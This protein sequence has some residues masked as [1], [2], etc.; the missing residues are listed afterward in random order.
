MPPPKYDEAALMAEFLKLKMENPV[1]TRSEFFRLKSI[2]VDYGLKKFGRVMDE[3]WTSV[4]QFSVQKIVKEAGLKLGDQMSRVFKVNRDLMEQA[5]KKLVSQKKGAKA[6][7]APETFADALRAVRTGTIGMVASAN[8][9]SGGEPLQE[10]EDIE[11]VLEMVEP[12]VAPKKKPK[13]TSKAKKASKP[14]AKPA[15]SEQKTSAGEQ[16]PPKVNEAKNP[17]KF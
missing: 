14:D 2:P 12:E 15:P 8:L 4:R 1:L 3:L 16:K 11:E 5:I 7:L 9:L 17:L 13:R 10:D 6:E